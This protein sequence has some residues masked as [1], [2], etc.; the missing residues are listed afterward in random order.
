MV[1]HT[2]TDEERGSLRSK[3][4]TLKHT[5]RGEH[6]KYLPKAFTEKKGLYMPATILKSARATETTF[7]IIEAFA[8]LRELSRTIGELSATPTSMPK[9]R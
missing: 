2:L 8:K 5:G 6:T 7:A 4:S 1:I 9:S 3:F